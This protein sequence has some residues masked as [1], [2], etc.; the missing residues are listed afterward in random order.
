ML[1]F[2]TCLSDR[3]LRGALEFVHAAASADASE[4][5]PQ[6]VLDLL[7]RVVPG[8]FVGYSEWE[9][10]T[11]PRATAS[12]DVPTVPTPAEV[13]EARAAYCSTYPLSIVLRASETRPLAIS[14]F[15]TLSQLHR[16]DYYDQVLRPFR[17]EHQLRLWLSAPRAKTR[18]FQFSRRGG[19]GDFGE[20][21]R[22]LLEFLRPFLVAVR[23]RFEFR[24]ASRPSASTVL[25]ERETEILHWIA[26]GKTNQEVALLLFVSPHTIRK[27]LENAY[28][29]LGV[30]TR[31]AAVARLGASQG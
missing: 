2:V 6:P 14:D 25:T 11:R 12:V 7:G 5:F 29:K 31:T 27:H 20:P 10:S 22:S 15:L 8:E 1:G 28:R 9:L 16:L 24:T 18:L 4:P 30:H 13:A 19:Q 23:E 26:R 17:I 3:Q 21:D